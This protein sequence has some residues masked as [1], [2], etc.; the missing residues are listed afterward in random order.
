MTAVSNS[1]SPQSLRVL[2]FEDNPLDAAL[3]KKFLLTVG[4]RSSNIH[5]VDTIPSAL[6]VLSREHIDVCLADYYLRPSTGFDLM[7]EARRY[8]VDVPFI[9]LTAM[10]DRI[11]D[12]G[13]LARGAYGFLVKGELTVEGL[14]RSIRY[15]LTHHARES[16]L[17]R[18]ALIDGLTGLPNRK[19]FHDRLVGAISDNAGRKGMVAIAIFNLNGTKFLNESYGVK[20]GDDVIR[21]TAAG[22]QEHKRKGDYL[23]R[24]GGDEFAMLMTDLLLPGHAIEQTKT[25]ATSLTGPVET[26]DGRHDVTLAAGVASLTAAQIG[27][28]E[29]AERLL[30][31]AAQAMFNAKLLAR[32]GGTSE[33]AVARLQ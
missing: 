20:V 22:F 28:A 33:V 21:A 29:A 10:D 6:Q 30:A 8:D 18:D 32:R 11:I 12:E 24:V 14:E 19:A 31:Q 3:I 27:A 9:M 5:H 26:R 13:A 7:D 25:L 17:A 2:L 4:M 16:T 23:A 1:F 15:T